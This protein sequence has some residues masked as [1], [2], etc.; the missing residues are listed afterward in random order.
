M[1]PDQAG[2]V[3]RGAEPNEGCRWMPLDLRR[4]SAPSMGDQPEPSN[5][6][7]EDSCAS[8]PTQTPCWNRGGK[9]G[10]NLK[11]KQLCHKGKSLHNHSAFSVECCGRSH[12][13]GKENGP[14]HEE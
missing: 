6:P 5:K 1:I 8:H 10:R 14:I 2:L 12:C 4:G 9:G 7:D 3:P 11:D 13:E